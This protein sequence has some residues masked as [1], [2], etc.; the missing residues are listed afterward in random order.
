MKSTANKYFLDSKNLREQLLEA[1][2]IYNDLV[3]NKA[4]PDKVAIAQKRLKELSQKMKESGVTATH[5]ES[6]K[7]DPGFN[8]SE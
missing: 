7:K 1:A 6:D 4:S 8:F 5:H 3:S 2:R